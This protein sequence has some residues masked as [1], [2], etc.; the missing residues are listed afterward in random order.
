MKN[1]AKFMVLTLISMISYPILAQTTSASFSGTATIN[2]TC[3]LN[4]DSVNFGEVMGNGEATYIYKNSTLNVLCSKDVP[5][6][7]GFTSLDNNSVEVPPLARK[8][9]GMNA[10]N[11]DNLT[12]A[13]F[14][15]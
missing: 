15:N 1:I 8:L 9:K 14:K 6:S 10:I 7:V 12:Y 4:A 5:F 11:T 13:L 2:P 3:I